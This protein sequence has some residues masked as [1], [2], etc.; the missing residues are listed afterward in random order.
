MLGI[1]VERLGVQR[2]AAALVVDVIRRACRTEA[3]RLT[4]QPLDATATARSVAEV[5]DLVHVNPQTVDRKQ[6]QEIRYLPREI[7][8]ERKRVRVDDRF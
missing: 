6:R 4:C 3:R 2:R 7:D 1:H 5:A 8:R